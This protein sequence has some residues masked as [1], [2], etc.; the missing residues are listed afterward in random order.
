MRCEA[1]CEICGQ[2]SLNRQSIFRIVSPNFVPINY[3]FPR[4]RFHSEVFH[5]TQLQVL[6]E[7]CCVGKQRIW[8]TRIGESPDNDQFVERLRGM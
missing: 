6:Q 2:S 1:G 5:T 8:E 7:R 3:E 4:M